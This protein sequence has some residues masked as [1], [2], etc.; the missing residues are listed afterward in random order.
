M[1]FDS[2]LLSQS[3]SAPPTIFW[4]LLPN[5]ILYFTTRLAHQSILLVLAIISITSSSQLASVYPQPPSI[6]TSLLPPPD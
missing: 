6:T 3:L 4:L 5:Q 1:N 2:Q